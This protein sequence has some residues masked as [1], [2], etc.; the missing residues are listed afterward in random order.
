MGVISRVWPYFLVHAERDA[1]GTV[2]SHR[3]F[4]SFIQ[5]LATG[6]AGLPV[7]M[8]TQRNINGMY[9][10]VQRVH[11]HEGEGGCCRFHSSD[12]V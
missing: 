6:A 1:V 2:V 10:V 3:I 12:V 8:K 9:S 7:S 5:P 4:G 11:E